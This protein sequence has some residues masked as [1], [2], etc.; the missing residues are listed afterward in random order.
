MVGTVADA[1]GALRERGLV[2]TRRRGGTHVVAP[3]PAEFAGWASLDLLLASPDQAL[4]PRMDR[5]IVQA[6]QARGVNA[7]G[8][9]QMV[10]PLRAAVPKSMAA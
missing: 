9:E 6:M 2:E 1:W 3:D 5:A 10:E 8:R 4:Q 7:W